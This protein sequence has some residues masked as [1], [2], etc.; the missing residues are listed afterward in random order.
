MDTAIAILDKK[1]DMYV[2]M[3]MH[4]TGP[5]KDEFFAVLSF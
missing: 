1:S 3:F 2:F 4:Y 5:K